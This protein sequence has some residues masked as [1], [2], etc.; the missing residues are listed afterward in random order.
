MNLKLII[1]ILKFSPYPDY[2]VPIK[3]KDPPY[4]DDLTNC[5]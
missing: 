3:Y 5:Q 2:L 1:V 4:L